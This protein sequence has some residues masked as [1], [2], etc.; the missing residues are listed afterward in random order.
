M[1]AETVNRPALVTAFC[2]AILAL[3]LFN[4][5]Y[6]F[7]GVYAPYGLFYSAIHTLLTVVLFAAI[8]GIWSMERWGVYL[9][10]GIIA[11]KLGLDLYTGAFHYASLLLLVPVIYFLA[12]LS[13]MK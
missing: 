11:L 1:S 3:G 2:S 5:V 7:T 12:I 10:A 6:T 13:K 8:S 9:F 4:I